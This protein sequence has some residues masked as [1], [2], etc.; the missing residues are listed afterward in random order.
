MKRKKGGKRNEKK[1]TKINSERNGKFK[2]S[3][4]WNKNELKKRN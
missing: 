3:M 2:Q 4:E 1:M